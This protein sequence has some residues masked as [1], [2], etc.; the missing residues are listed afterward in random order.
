MQNQNEHEIVNICNEI[1]VLNEWTQ[2]KT[3]I[4]N[5]NTHQKTKSEW[6]KNKTT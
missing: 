1:N 6:E 2:I 4:H 3:E 5:Q